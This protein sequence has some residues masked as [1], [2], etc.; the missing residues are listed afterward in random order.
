MYRPSSVAVSGSKTALGRTLLAH[1]HAGGFAGAVGTDEAPIE[2]ADFALI[3]DDAADIS[4]ALAA[5]AKRGV[6]GAII[7][8]EVRDLRNLARQAG[9][10]VLGPYSFGMMLP[11]L[12]LNATPLPVMPAAGKVAY[13]GQ[14]GALL[15]TVLDWAVPNYIGFSKII[16]IGGNRDMGFGLVLDHLSRD[17]T[18]NAIMIEIDRVRDPQMFYSAVRAA[19]RLRPVVALVPGLRLRDGDGMSRAAVEAGFARSGVLLT[20]TISEFLAA[21]ETLTRVKPAHGESLAIVSNSVAGGRLAADDALHHGLHLTELAPETRQVMALTLGAEP[22]PLGPIFTGRTG[23]PTKLADAAAMLASAHEVGGILV[24]HAPSGEGD[25]V[26][27]EALIACAKTVKIPLLIAAMGEASGL[28]H[29]HRLAQ[30]GLACFDTPE[31]AI[32][33]FRH[34]IRN[35]ANRAAARELPPS[36]VLRVAP[37]TQAAANCV[38]AIRA[39]GR[40]MLVQNEAL[41]LLAAYNVAVVKGAKAKTPEEAG[42]MAA[43]LGFPVVLKLSH[44]DLPTNRVA[45]SVAL[46]LPDGKAVRA[47]ARAML[48]RLGPQTAHYPGLKFLV[49]QQ[50]PRG[51]QLRIRVADSPQLGPVIAFGAGG[52]DPDDVAGL[53]VDLPPLNLPLAHALIARSGVAAQLAAHRGAPAADIEAVAATLVRVS[54]L[55]IDMPEIL[56]LDLDP[57]FAYA[58]GVVAGS[59]RILLRP[60]GE[61]APKLL[62]APYPAELS[63]VYEAKGRKFTLRPI[64]PED[65]DAYTALFSRVSPEDMRFRFFSAMRSLAPE[66]IARLTDIDYGRE[67]AIVAVNE[68]AGQIAGA[69]RLVRND[70]DGRTA[71]FA[72]LVEPAAKGLGLASK[73]MREI[74][75]WGKAQGVE[76]IIGTILADNTPMLGFVKSLG[77]SIERVADDHDVVEA[78]LVP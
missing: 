33:G 25:E 70:T 13:V 48:T 73:L 74:I 71:E 50:A 69:A 57:L 76:E 4:R 53:A 56:L 18:T 7:L 60:E 21:A 46:D 16:G 78:R 5:H 23:G 47:A 44:P 11:G 64:R 40:T 27:I 17:A 63:S 39:A 34:L 32:A 49:Q 67:M 58:T 51:V 36:K 8:S 31:A 72:V 19:A 55:I 30:A 6:R 14:S 20:G 26:A 45:G 38:A 29:R 10:R 75:A 68:A 77:F 43:T 15:R 61:A 62:I 28:A 42:L 35:R 52:G 3:A 41:A 22:P 1:I 12:K 24:V 65:A 2:N 9:M 54:Q 59:G 66:Q 37:D